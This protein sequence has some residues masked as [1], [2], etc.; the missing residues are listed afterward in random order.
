MATGLAEIHQEETQH[1]VMSVVSRPQAATDR[2]NLK[3]SNKTD[4]IYDI[5]CP[6]PFKSLKFKI[7]FKYF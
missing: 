3:P 4:L 2:K 6:N 7:F 1:L 5:V